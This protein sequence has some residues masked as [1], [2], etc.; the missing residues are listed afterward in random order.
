MQHL[1]DTLSNAT[2]VAKTAQ[3][4][5]DAWKVFAEPGALAAEAAALEVLAYRILGIDS[6]SGAEPPSKDEVA[7]ARASMEFTRARQNAAWRSVRE[8][9]T[10][11][12][13]IA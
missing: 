6:G 9:E 2:L 13:K 11:L 3:T 12:D 7:L 5:R 10:E 8:M 4:G 1:I